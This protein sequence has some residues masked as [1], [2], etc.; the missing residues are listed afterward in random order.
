MSKRVKNLIAAELQ[1]RLAGMDSVVVV[2]YAGINANDTN[3]LRGGL[4]KKN[5]RFTVVP[6]AQ[7]AKALKAL[8]LPG[9]DTLL[10]GTNAL[11]YGGDSV[12][13]VVKE[14]V[15]Q[16]RDLAKLRIKGS[17]VEGRLFDRKAT[18]ALADMPTRK[19]LRMTIL[20]QALT[21]AGRLAGQIVAPGRRV[22]GLVQAVIQKKEKE[23]PAKDAAPE[24]A[25]RGVGVQE[26]N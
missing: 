6:N 26:S 4:R 19:E 11:A 16:A 2:D 25:G 9:A 23:T 20:A 12:V 17:V 5:V 21:P 14:L 22:A 18:E 1:K 3:R 13:D 8:G 7:A 24:P 15:A 10:V